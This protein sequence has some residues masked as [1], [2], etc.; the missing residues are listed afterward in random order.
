[1]LAKLESR[2]E[3]T[4]HDGALRA[5][6]PAV[7]RALA[8]LHSATSLRLM[9]RDP[10]GFLWRYAMGM[11]SDPARSNFRWHWMR[12]PSAN[13]FTNCSDAPSTRSNPPPDSFV[14]RAMR[15]KTALAG[16]VSHVAQ[17]WPLERPAPPAL[18]WQYSLDEAARRGLRGLTIDESFEPD[19][20]SWSEVEFGLPVAPQGRAFAVDARRRDRHRNG[21]AEIGR[22]D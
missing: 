10:L 11:R 14:R 5:D 4:P 2:A 12:S 22:A 6:H 8:R 7:A 18:L 21:K 15:S 1:M 9:V 3:A 16:A 19:T 13:S 17:Q 20:T